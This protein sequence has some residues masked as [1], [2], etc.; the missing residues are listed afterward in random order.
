MTI[1]TPPTV[2]RLIDFAAAHPGR[3]NGTVDEAI[4]AELGV[5]PARYFQLLSRAIRTQ[6][7]Q[8]HDPVTTHRLLRQTDQQARISAARTTV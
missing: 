8:A 2:E 7:A 4:R 3:F 6:A 1:T 5:T